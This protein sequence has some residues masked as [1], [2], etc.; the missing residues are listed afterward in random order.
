MSSREEKIGNNTKRLLLVLVLLTLS[1]IFS[2]PPPIGWAVDNN[3]IDAYWLSNSLIYQESSGLKITLWGLIDSQNDIFLHWFEING[4]LEY[5]PYHVPILLGIL[6]FIGGI[7]AMCLL[8]ILFLKWNQSSN[9][10]KIILIVEIIFCINLVLIL[11]L[12]EM[13]LSDLFLNIG[14]VANNS[15]LKVSYGYYFDLHI[16][17]CLLLL[18]IHRRIKKNKETNKRTDEEVIKELLNPQEQKPRLLKKTQFDLLLVSLIFLG[19]L[20]TKKLGLWDLSLFSGTNYEVYVW[21]LTQADNTSL[22]IHNK[23]LFFI[24]WSTFC[25][26]VLSS[27]LSILSSIKGELISR[28][29]KY[30][31][32]SLLLNILLIL[33]SVI[34]F[35]YILPFSKIKWNW[36]GFLLV[37]LMFEL[38]LYLKYKQ[39]FGEKDKKKR[40]KQKKEPA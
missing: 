22:F 37:S 36:S 2:I 28:I 26:G 10:I 8:S 7:V 33:I 21:G 39:I 15:F 4:L 24:N 29:R 30:L 34:V 16:C 38:K 25:F 32:L 23:D 11:L 13:F 12:K 19:L 31:N 5:F 17:N 20:F 14:D 35:L 9:K 1:L 6:L 3:G 18:I 40:E 27:F